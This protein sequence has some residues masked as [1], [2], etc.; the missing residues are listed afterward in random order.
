VPFW[1]HLTLIPQEDLGT[2]GRPAA[3]DQGLQGYSDNPIVDEDS[4]N[5]ELGDGDESDN[6]DSEDHLFTGKVFKPGD[7]SG[8]DFEE[9]MREKIDTLCEF[10]NRL[11]YQVQF[12]DSRMLQALEREGGSVCRWQSRV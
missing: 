12:R 8:Q 5:E 11:E 9:V 4:D 2:D 3:S 7:A 6:D 1:K 10:M